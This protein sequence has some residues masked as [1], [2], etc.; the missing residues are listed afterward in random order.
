MYSTLSNSGWT[1]LRGLP[2]RCLGSGSGYIVARHRAAT[3]ISLL[4]SSHLHS[5]RVV[6]HNSSSPPPANKRVS[7][8]HG[9]H[10]RLLHARICNCNGAFEISLDGLARFLNARSRFFLQ[11]FFP[12]F[13]GILRL[14]RPQGLPLVLA[15]RRLRPRRPP[16]LRTNQVISKQHMSA[17]M[18]PC[19][20]HLRLHSRSLSSIAHTQVRVRLT[21]PSADRAMSHRRRMTCIWD[22]THF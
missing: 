4:F 20:A 5:W 13:R 9:W 17:C 2:C 6:Q 22:R 16:P 1:S 8:V 14:P 15:Q 10:H 12:P 18:M 11:P 19:H 3:A 7:K 21:F